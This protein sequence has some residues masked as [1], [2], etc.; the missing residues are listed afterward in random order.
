ML[1]PLVTNQQFAN[2]NACAVA[3][4]DIIYHIGGA[5]CTKIQHNNYISTFDTKTH[6]YADFYLID[7]NLPP[8]RDIHQVYAVSYNRKIYCYFN[9]P[10][11]HNQIYIID[12]VSGTSIRLNP[13]NQIILNDYN[14][15]YASLFEQDAKNPIIYFFGTK[16]KNETSDDDNDNDDDDDDTSTFVVIMYNIVTNAMTEQYQT[17]MGGS[18]CENKFLC[19]FGCNVRNKY[20]YF[21]NCVDIDS[22]LIVWRYDIQNKTLNHITF[23]DD[24]YLPGLQLVA[25]KL[26]IT[27]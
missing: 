4:D 14:I 16:C 3:I 27:L 10:N 7:D 22:E 17:C 1:A 15:T 9:G 19:N 18:L 20:F 26:D 21:G 25:L 5:C 12:P 11:C 2:R 13:F 24:K 23:V 8:I 6:K